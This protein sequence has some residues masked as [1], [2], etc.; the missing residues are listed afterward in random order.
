MIWHLHEQHHLP[1]PR[2]RFTVEQISDWA[3]SRLLD[4]KSASRQYFSRVIDFYTK[5]RTPGGDRRLIYELGSHRE[6]EATAD[7]LGRVA[8]SHSEKIRVLVS[9]T[10]P[11][12][13]QLPPHQKALLVFWLNTGLRPSSLLRLFHL[14]CTNTTA[15]VTTSMMKWKA[16]WQFRFTVVCCCAT[17]TAPEAWCLFH[18]SHANIQDLRI[19][20][21]RSDVT[22]LLRQLRCPAVALRKTYATS[23]KLARERYPRDVTLQSIAKAFA[24]Q[25]DGAAALLRR[26]SLPPLATQFIP[27]RGLKRQAILLSTQPHL[28]EPQQAEQEARQLAEQMIAGNT[29]STWRQPSAAPVSAH[30]ISD[31]PAF[32]SPLDWAA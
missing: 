21:E 6:I 18:G 2:T 30:S 23:L 32:P 25:P 26:Y 12:I 20:V 27:L 31:L 19:P 29:P 24:W 1:T 28:K 14:E 13:P 3:H 16:G 22:T 5:S 15:Q 7:S 9:L 8:S 17:P 4:S 11:A 10:H